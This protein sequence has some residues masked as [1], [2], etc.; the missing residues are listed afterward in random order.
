MSNLI[1][2]MLCP[3]HGIMRCFQKNLLELRFYTWYKRRIKWKNPQSFYDKIIWMSCNAD[4]SLWSWLANKYK[5]REYVITRCTDNLLPKFYGVFDASKDIEFDSLPNSFVAK[6]NNGCASNI[7]VKDKEKADWKSI[8]KQLDK[9]L[10]YPYGDLTGQ[11]HYSEIKPKIIVEELF[12]DKNNP[13]ASLIDYKF[14][15]FNG[16]PFYCFVASD[17]KPNTHNVYRMLYDMEWKAVPNAFTRQAKLKEIPRPICFERMKQIAAM[18]SKDIN[19]V[20]VDLYEV[21]GSVRFGEM[22]FMPGWDNHFTEEILLKWGSSF[23]KKQLITEQEMR[24]KIGLK[25]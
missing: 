8:C 18:L 2:N 19:F 9:W 4:T 14:Y 7:F 20:R 6:T 22:T 23:D 25:N 3:F 1:Y 11:L 15:C 17:R 12:V 5:V 24:K 13:T 21:N 10:K 16:Q